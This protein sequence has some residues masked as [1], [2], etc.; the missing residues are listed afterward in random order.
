MCWGKIDVI[1]IEVDLFVWVWG[2][3]ECDDVVCGKW[4]NVWVVRCGM[5][6]D[7]WSKVW[8]IL[9][10][11]DLVCFDYVFGD[12]CYCDGNILDVLFVFLSGDDDFVEVGWCS[13]IVCVLS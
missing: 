8:E 2:W 12:C 11:D 6:G 7:V 5:N 10:V 3:V 1:K 9:D 13:V 4:G